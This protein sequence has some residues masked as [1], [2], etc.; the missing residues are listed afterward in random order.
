MH[1]G[2]VYKNQLLKS[3]AFLYTNNEQFKKQ[4]KKSIPF[5][6]AWNRI[7]YLWINLTKDMKN[8]CT[9]DYKHCWN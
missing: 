1:K 2:A 4:I 3:V 7:K 5:T 6:I 9:D 8:V